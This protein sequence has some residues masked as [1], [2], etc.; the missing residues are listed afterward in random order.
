MIFS[1]LNRAS[2]FI[3]ALLLAATSY[4]ASFT[5]SFDENP[6]YPP[7][8][9]NGFNYRL[10]ETG[11]GSLSF[12]DSSITGVGI[13]DVNLSDL[14]TASFSY[15]LTLIPGD[16]TTQFTNSDITSPVEFEFDNGV[17]DGVT[18]NATQQSFRD[19]LTVSG[20][21]YVHLD[22]N[23]TYYY[24]PTQGQLTIDDEGTLSFETVTAFASSPEPASVFLIA[25]A[26]APL[27][28][29]RYRRRS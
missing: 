6:N 14:T 15:S 13:E 17:L 1:F 21:T 20:D 12:D 22:A 25:G 18:F 9:D 27:A 11:G 29:R 8:S 3:P 23:N 7:N 4:G 19:T 2:R 24:G 16:Y 26:L 5:F 10:G 28:W